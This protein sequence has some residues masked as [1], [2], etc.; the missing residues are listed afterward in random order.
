MDG[1]SAIAFWENVVATYDPFTIGFVGTVAVQIFFWWT[2][3]IIFFI[4]DQFASSFS[5]KHKLQPAAKQAS[6]G[7][8]FCAIIVAARN[9][10]FTSALHLGLIYISVRQGYPSAVRVEAKLPTLAEFTREFLI[11]YV[12]RQV[13]VYY[14]HRLLHWRPLYHRF[15]KTHHMFTAPM[16]FSS[17]YAH[18]FDHI[19]TN[20]LPLMLPTLLM[21]SHILTMWAYIAWELIQAA[22]NHSG[23]DF[24]FVARMH[25]VH[26]EKKVVYYG[27]TGDFGLLDWLH[28]TDGEGLRHRKKLN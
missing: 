11:S 27:S 21:N 8:V 16:A 26:H 25:D 5:Q 12:A 9:Q 1:I 23:Y 4:L 28:G 7:A 14:S 13:M 10:G 18:P 6:L 20:V 19:L 17:Q 15:H 24:F 2:P 22:V 3:C